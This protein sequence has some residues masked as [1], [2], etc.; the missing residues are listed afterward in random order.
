MRFL[1]F[2]VLLIL[3]S[4][5]KTTSSGSGASDRSGRTPQ[6][7]L[8]AVED[9][10]ET[11]LLDATVDLP[12]EVTGSQ[13]IFKRAD[14]QAMTGLYMTCS[15]GV[16]FGEAWDYEL[17]GSD[18]L[19]ISTGGRSYTFKRVTPGSGIIGGWNWREYDG[20]TLYVRRMTFVTSNR[21]IIRTHCER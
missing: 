19:I 21:V 12:V 15:V 14:T 10:K 16:A 2:F 3:V 17:D 11:D 7:Q 6:Y 13:I 18:T 20:E 9:I 1:F 8:G 4:C 5:G